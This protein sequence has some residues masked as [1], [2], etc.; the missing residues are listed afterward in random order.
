MADLWKV[1]NDNAGAL[2]VI[3]VVLPVMWA[4]WRYLGL[5]R[6]EL[7]DQRFQTYHALVRQLVE[8][9]DGDKVMRLDRQ[10]AVAFEL[11]RFPEYFEPSLRILKGLRATWGDGDS[12][13]ER[14]RLLEEMDATVG[15]IE[16]KSGSRRYRLRRAVRGC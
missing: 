9:E 5:K 8:P 2:G 1:L 10:L 7:R 14:R 11:R 13:A 16:K 6:R 15:H 12:V 3:L 4:A